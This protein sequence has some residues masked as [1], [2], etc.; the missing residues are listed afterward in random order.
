MPRK[1]INPLDSLIPERRQ[2]S[3][4][5][6]EKTREALSSVLP[7]SLLVLLISLLWVPVEL[8]TISLFLLGACLL[9]AGMGLFTLGADMAMMPMGTHLGARLTR[10]MDLRFLV[11]VAFLLGM[12]ITVAEPDLTVLANQVQGVPNA[13]LI[14]AVSAGVGVFL[15]AALLRILFQWKLRYLLMGVYGAIFL[16][17][18]L[19]KPEFVPMAFDAGGV[20][21]GPMTV[22]FILALGVGIANVHSGRSAQDD[23]FGLVALSSAGPILAIMLVSLFFPRLAN[24]PKEHAASALATTRDVTAAYRQGLPVYGR[25]VLLALAPIAL[26]FFG[27]QLFSLHLPGQEIKRM[28]VGL[29][30]TYAGLVLFLTGVNI[31]FLPLGDDLGRRLGGGSDRWLL[32]PL[33]MLIGFLAVRAEPA[34]HVLNEQVEQVTSGTVSKKVMMRTMSLGVACSVGLAMTRVLTGLSIWYFLVPGYLIALSLS[35]LTE[36]IFTA[37]AF[38]SGGVAS[39]PMTA[40]FMLPLF[41]GACGA[42]GGNILEDAFGVVAMVA[43]TPLI[44]IQILGLV[45]RIRTRKQPVRPAP[46]PGLADVD[47]E[48]IDV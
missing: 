9:V 14:L 36:P 47:D 27:F 29:L 19:I 34:V 37:I 43:M 21:T 12:L 46:A 32:L 3:K 6:K 4:R 35:F 15:V 11:I 8:G 30:Y 7:I 17:G 42:M 38:D 31:G 1:R 39:G 28:V 5:L 48:I 33:G 18:A 16:L 44:A 10:K 22:P 20:T 45:Y 40:A 41:M 2:T 25:E 26:L 24:V 23:S 13:T